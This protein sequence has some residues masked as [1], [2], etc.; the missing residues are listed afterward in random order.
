MSH[1]IVYGPR[2]GSAMRVFWALEELGQV[3]EHKTIDMAHGEHKQEAFL[4]INPVGQVPAASFDGFLMAESLAI[5]RYACEKY[6]PELLGVTPES[7]AKAMQ[8]ELFVILNIQ[9]HLATLASVKWGMT[10][11]EE[12]TARAHERLNQF[13][14]LLEVYLAKTEFLSGAELTIADINAG[15]AFNYATLI[16]MDLSMYP[17]I[18]K[19]LSVLRA[20]PSFVKGMNG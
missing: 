3:Y 17:A 16:D 6:K 8:W 18:T 10:P 14:P 12:Q 1:I 11:T 13:L 7:R 9:Q 2:G 5:T 4:A 19:W 20:R 15:A